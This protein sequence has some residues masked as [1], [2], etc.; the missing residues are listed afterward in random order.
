MTINTSNADYTSAALLGGFDYTLDN[1]AGIQDTASVIVTATTGDTLTGGRED[2]IIISGTGSD[3]LVGNAGDD[4]LIGN[5]GVDTLQGGDGADLLI[6]GM[7]NDSLIGGAG[8]DIFALEAGDEGTGLPAIDTIADFTVGTG[9]DVLDLSDMLSGENLGNLD[10]YLNFSYDSGTGDTTINVDVT[11]SAGIS[12]QI[13]LS[14]VDLTS[15]STLSDQ[16]ILDNLL[17]THN[18]IIDQ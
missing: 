3:I 13:V 17:S 18:L 7:G 14:G 16:Q 12:Q 2:E 5:E 11:G 15:N 4:V 10:N 8:I 6:G 9:G 1:G